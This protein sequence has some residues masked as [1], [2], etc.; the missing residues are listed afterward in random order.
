ME[1]IQPIKF[2]VL[3]ITSK[4]TVHGGCLFCKLVDM[5]ELKYVILLFDSLSPIVS[6][7]TLF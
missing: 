4:Y 3:I 5:A 6:T 7:S 2:S 1:D